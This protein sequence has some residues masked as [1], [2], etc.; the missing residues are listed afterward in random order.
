VVTD[1]VFPIVGQHL[2]VLFVVV[3]ARKIKVIKVQVNAKLA[4]CGIQ[5]AYSFGHDFFANAVT[6]NNGY[7]VYCHIGFL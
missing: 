3:P 6:G 5:H 7:G 2:A 4:R 1:L